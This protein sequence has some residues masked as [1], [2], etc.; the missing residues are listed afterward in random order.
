MKKT[1]AITL[2]S[3]LLVGAVNAQTYFTS[4]YSI[5][6]PAGDLSDFISQASFRG[7]SLDYRK[8]VQPNIGVG[9]NI[10][11]N[12]FYE[13]MSRATYTLDNQSLTGKQ[14]RYSNHFPML[15]S[16]NYYLKPGET[17]N[18]FVGLGIGTV[19]TRRNTDMNLYTLEQEAWNFALQPEVGFHYTVNDATALTFMLKYYNGFKAS[20]EL[21]SAQ[22]YL[23]IC[24][25]FTFM[26]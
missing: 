26:N 12:V 7:F 25:G 5:G 14:Y 21:T 16:T 19:Y 18:P 8:L 6:M 9:F 23:A 3:L 17:L 11:W 10:A 2:F 13:E 20:S 22:S 1:F 15:V 24:V 4:S